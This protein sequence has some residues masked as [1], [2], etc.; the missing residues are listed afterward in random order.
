MRRLLL[1]PLL[2]LPFLAVACSD[3]ADDEPVPQGDIVSDE[4]YLRVF[5][6]GITGFQEAL[7]NSKTVEGISEAV[8]TYVKAMEPVNPPADIADFHKAYIKYL[9]DAVKGEDPTVLVTSK[10]PVPPDGPRKRLAD[11]A[12]NVEACKYPTFLNADE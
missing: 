9:K 10:P 2:C 5:C 3:D 7:L 6:A 1:L 4:D 11:K 8:T 12:G